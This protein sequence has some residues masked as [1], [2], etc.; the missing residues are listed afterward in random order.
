MG[1]D[2]AGSTS[3]R[4]GPAMRRAVAGLLVLACLAG[5]ARTAP[6][7]EPALVPP[8]GAHL[9]LGLAARDETGR[10]TTL[11][12]AAEGRPI[13]LVFADYSCTA[14]CGTALGLLASVLPDTGLRAGE[15]FALLAIGLDPRDGPA[16]AASMRRA[17][18]GDGTRAG[19]AAR[20]LV[21]EPAAVS[22][23]TEALGY[24]TVYHP[25]SDLFAHPLAVMVLAPDGRVV[26]A[27]PGLGLGAGEL[28]SALKDAARPL[29]AVSPTL[30]QRAVL[31]CR[32]FAA[33][34]S[35]PRGIALAAAIAAGAATVAA[36]LAG[37]VLLL[38][39]Q[40]RR[41]A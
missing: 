41:R 24:R 17:H 9:P 13:A 31:V 40:R 11:R 35:G 29:P 3:G 33:P 26:A 10:P 39:V 12:A 36:G 20:F 16:E 2:A 30:L 32:G 19:A 7:E 5:P 22:A 23:A 37:L 14:L 38:R 34:G 25:E 21:A 6:A 15:D 18:F 4:G 28:R 27:L 8:P 1:S